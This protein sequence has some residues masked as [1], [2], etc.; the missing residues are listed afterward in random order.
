[1][2]DSYGS[3]LFQNAE[4]EQSKTMSEFKS[5]YGNQSSGYVSGESQTCNSSNIPGLTP[6]PPLINDSTLPITRNH[7]SA[8]LSADISGF[9]KFS[10]MMDVEPLSNAINSYF[11]MIVNVITSFGGDILKFAGDAV[12]AK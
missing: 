5:L 8:L 2:E 3:H 10:V 11:Q 7:S 9:T 12:L 4:N 6:L 1:M